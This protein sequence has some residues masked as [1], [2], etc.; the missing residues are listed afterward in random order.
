MSTFATIIQHTSGSPSY[1]N[2]RRK[3]NKRN[4]DGKRRSKAL[5]VADNMI[6]YIENLKIVSENYQSL[7][8]NLAKFQDTK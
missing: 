2:Q 5:T 1:S 7:S 6:L 3:R 8:V 4:P